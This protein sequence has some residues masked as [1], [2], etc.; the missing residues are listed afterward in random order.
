MNSPPIAP[1]EINCTS[2]APQTSGGETA[3]GRI[4]AAAAPEADGI[5]NGDNAD[6]I[7]AAALT[8]LNSVLALL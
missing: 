1:C 2:S 3:D 4:F 8:I 6:S 5:I 7:A